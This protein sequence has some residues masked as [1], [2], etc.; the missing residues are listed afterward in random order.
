MNDEIKIIQTYLHV[1]E[2]ANSCNLSFD[3]VHK[4][5]PSPIY[6][7]SNK[8]G[9][10]AYNS[11]MKKYE[12]AFFDIESAMHFIQGYQAAFNLKKS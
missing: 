2:I 3:I 1:K 11:S 7:L 6:M 4:E 10:G 9:S 8:Y 5:I 12:Q